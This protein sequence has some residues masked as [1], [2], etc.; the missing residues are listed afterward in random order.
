MQIARR[1]V[2]QFEQSCA[3]MVGNINMLKS[4]LQVR[5]TMNLSLT[6][7]DMN[8][9][10]GLLSIQDDIRKTFSSQGIKPEVLNTLFGDPREYHVQTIHFLIFSVKIISIY[11]LG[12][13]VMTMKQ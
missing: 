3:G 9:F 12:S 6:A 2:K 1:L 11:W 10:K 8:N 5:D 4:I 13:L 7:Y